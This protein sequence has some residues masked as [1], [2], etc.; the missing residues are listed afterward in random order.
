MCLLDAIS[1]Y[2]VIALAYLDKSCL[3]LS[4]F[5][6]LY[7]DFCECSFKIYSGKLLLLLE[8]AVNCYLW[9]VGDFISVN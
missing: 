7:I 9:E 6:V 3:T 4:V 8:C 1:Y 2:G 5:Y